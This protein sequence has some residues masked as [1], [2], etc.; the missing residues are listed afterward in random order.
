[1]EIFGCN[2]RL[3]TLQ[4]VIGNR[5]I[6]EVEFITA[7]RI[8]NAGRYDAAFADM[9]D[10]VRVPVRREGVKHV[11]HLYVLR[12]RDRDGLLAHLQKQGVE[13]KIH[14]P[15]PVHLQKAAA[16]LGYKRGDFPVCELD[17][18]RIITLPAHQH[19]SNAE[20]DYTIQKVREFYG[21]S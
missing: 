3:D 15:I 9:G 12:V 21:R 16:D 14:Y 5:L 17:C 6:Q 19:L 11:F 2:C 20:I 13:A 8:E 4:A 18:D 10:D 1:V 7:R